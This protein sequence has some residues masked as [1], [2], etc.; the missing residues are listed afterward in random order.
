MTSDETDLIP[1]SVISDRKDARHQKDVTFPK[2]NTTNTTASRHWKPK[3][4]GPLGEADLAAVREGLPRSSVRD[5]QTKQ[6]TEQRTE[7]DTDH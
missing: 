4:V 7:N 3:L 1:E 2:L 6:K 5:W